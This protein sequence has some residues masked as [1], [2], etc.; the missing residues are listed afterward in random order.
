MSMNGVA[1]SKLELKDVS[2]I[3]SRRGKQF[4]ALRDVSMQVEAGQ[5]ISLVGASGCGKTT[6]LRIVDGLM[7]PSG[8]EIWVDGKPVTR[9]GPDRGFV[10]QQDA[11][12]P[13]RT[14][15]DNIVFGLEVQGKPKR[16]SRSRA[17]ELIR[18]VGLSGFEQHFPHELSGG[19][20]QRANLARALTIDPDILLMDEPFASLDAQTRELMQSELLRI[21]R[22]NRKTVMF[23][24]H[25]IDEAVFLADR[26]VVMTSRPGQIKAMLD[27]NIPRPRDLSVKRTQPFLDLVDAIWKMI[28]EEVKAA[29][30]ITGD[31][32]VIRQQLASY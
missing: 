4:A 14:V 11:L 27:V 12:F 21:W 29:L 32:S 18:L 8:G 17:D 6:L 20:R 25:Q 2:M 9:P 28:E 19:M 31:G 15:L 1:H 16:E 23:V 3:Y 13:W 5:F 30:R 10:F 24:T 7:A 22:S 26:V